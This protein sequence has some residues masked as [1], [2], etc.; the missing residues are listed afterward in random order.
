MKECLTTLTGTFGIEILSEITS[1]SLDE[2][3]DFCRT[4]QLYLEAL[5]KGQQRPG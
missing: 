4:I 2:Y 5:E 3:N 1:M